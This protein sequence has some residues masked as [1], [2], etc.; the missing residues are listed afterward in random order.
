MRSGVMSLGRDDGHALFGDQRFPASYTALWCREGGPVYAGKAVLGEDYLLLT[1][2]DR[3]GSQA[4]EQL[5]MSELG[6]SRVARG[7]HERL[8]GRPALVLVNSAGP[9]LR[10]AVLD[11]GGTLLELAERLTG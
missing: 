9:P 4:R 3:N 7:R 2:V 10:L 8:E 6:V 5:G 11:G 1:G